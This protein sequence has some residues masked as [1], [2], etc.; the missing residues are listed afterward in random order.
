[1]VDRRPRVAV[2]GGTTEEARRKV[3]SS[4]LL[5]LVDTEAQGKVEQLRVGHAN[6]ARKLGHSSASAGGSTGGLTSGDTNDKVKGDNEVGHKGG[7]DVGN[8]QVKVN[9]ECDT[10]TARKLR[11]ILATNG[12][13]GVRGRVGQAVTVGVTTNAE[14]VDTNVELILNVVVLK[15]DTLNIPA[16]Y[17]KDGVTDTLV[18]GEIGIGTATTELARHTNVGKDK[19]IGGRIIDALGRN[20]I[21]HE[22]DTK[23]TRTSGGRVEGRVREIGGSVTRKDGRGGRRRQQTKEAKERKANKGRSGGHGKMSTF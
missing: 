14:T 12:N 22:K 23:V 10:F 17:G 16:G 3:D 11:N 6:G 20:R 8:V 1:V 2:E 15:E 5:V 18:E 4:R 7:K 19:R 21:R 9:D 13:E